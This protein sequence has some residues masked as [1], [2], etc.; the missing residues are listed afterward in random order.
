MSTNEIKEKIRL[1]EEKL[2]QRKLKKEEK[3][4]HFHGDFYQ[5]RI[6]QLD[7]RVREAKENVD[8]I[9]A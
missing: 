5:D 2:N 4:E 6:S 8:R 1:L 3:Y 7:Q 9:R